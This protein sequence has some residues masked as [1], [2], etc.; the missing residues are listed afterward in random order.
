MLLLLLALAYVE[1]DAIANDYELSAEPL[2]DLFTAMGQQDQGP[3]IEA[4]LAE[5]GSPRDAILATLDGLDA[6]TYLGTAGVSPA[7]LA[8]IRHRLLECGCP[9]G[10]G[11]AGRQLCKRC[12][13]GL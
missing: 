13:Q 2:K 3:I 4:A 10:T 11:S 12:R 1:P 7:D 9:H 6:E 8:T 5:R